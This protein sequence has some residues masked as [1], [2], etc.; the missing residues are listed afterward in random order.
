MTSP[1]LERLSVSP[2]PATPNAFI[3]RLR[4]PHDLR[5]FEGHFDQNPMLPGVAEILEVV[6]REARH[7]FP[8]LVSAGA[9]RMTRLK[10]LAVILPGDELA[11]HLSLSTEGEPQLRYRIDRVFADRAETAASGALT[12][13]A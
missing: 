13:T 10:F 9:K 12:Y 2:D 6:D 3:A 5:H 1:H 11:V 4:V 7:A 8:A